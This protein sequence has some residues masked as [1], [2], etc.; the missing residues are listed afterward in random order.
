MRQG[1]NNPKNNSVNFL[2]FIIPFVPCLFLR[3]FRASV[4][5]PPLRALCLPPLQSSVRNLPLLPAQRGV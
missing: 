1:Q 4:R 2:N 5:N 3:A